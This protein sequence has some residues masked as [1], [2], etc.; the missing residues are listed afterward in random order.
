MKVNVLV[1][2]CGW[3]E[4]FADGP[5]SEKYGPH[6]TKASRETH[7]TSAITL[8]EVFKRMCKLGE[9]KAF[10]A[11]TSIISSTNVV[12]VDE[13]IALLAAD[14]SL[15]HGLSVSDAVIKATAD[16]Y[17]AKVVTSDKHLGK[18]EGVELVS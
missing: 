16:T 5:L 3:I 15:K 6:V 2:S 13:R 11:C 18:L 1:D 8:Y 14:L 9:K 12:P 17:K 7:Y 4:Y 10:E